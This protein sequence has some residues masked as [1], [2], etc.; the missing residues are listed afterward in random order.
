MKNLIIVPCFKS[1]TNLKKGQAWRIYDSPGFK[2]IRQCR[3]HRNP[4][5]DLYII[6]GKHGLIN[7]ERIIRKH[8]MMTDEDQV[9]DLIPQ[10]L[11]AIEH[12]NAKKYD[13]A[14]ILINN[15]NSMYYIALSPL[16]QKLKDFNVPVY[17]PRKG[18]GNSDNKAIRTRYLKTIA[19]DI[20]GGRNVRDIG[21]Y[22]A[23]G[24]CFVSSRCNTCSRSILGLQN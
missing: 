13:K 22:S 6:S 14:Y 8:N 12:I 23:V 16:I 11:E 7:D 15:K 18:K 19:K 17:R 2:V 10:V 1:K 20:Q 5:V 24:H 21:L 3:L 9:V 4:E